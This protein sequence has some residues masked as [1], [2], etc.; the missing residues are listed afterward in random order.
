MWVALS[1]SV[2]VGPRD[3]ALPLTRCHFK[4]SNQALSAVTYVLAPLEVR[5]EESR[6]GFVRWARFAC[7]YSR[8][9]IATDKMGALLM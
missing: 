8:H 3:G 5:H 6:I 1:S 9:L 4:V 7:L 2:R